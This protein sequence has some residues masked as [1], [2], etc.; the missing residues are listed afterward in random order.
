MNLNVLKSYLIKL[1]VQVDDT[2]VNKMKHVVNDLTG[3]VSSRSLVMSKAALRGAGVIVG[4]LASVD[5]AIIKN[6]MNVAEADMSYQL[7]AQK[8]FMTADAAKAFKLSSDALDASLFEIAWNAE[9]KGRY[10]ELV[11][12]INSLKTPPEAREMFREVRETAFQFT[13][14]KVSAT[15]ALEHISYNII[16]MNRGPLA[17]FRHDLEEMV[18]RFIKNLPEWSVKVAKWLNV[19]AKLSISGM[20]VVGGFFK[21]VKTV[22][23]YLSEKLD[24]LFDK[25]PKGAKSGALLGALFTPQLLLA[26]GIGS[27]FLAGMTT[28]VGLLLMIDDFIGRQEGRKTS[29]FLRPFWEIVEW[30]TTGFMEIVLGA[31]VLWD[32][33]TWKISHPFTDHP[34]GLSWSEDAWKQIGDYG[35]YADEWIRKRSGKTAEESIGFSSIFES[36]MSSK[37]GRPES[38]AGQGSSGFFSGITGDFWGGRKSYQ[39]LGFVSPLADFFGKRAFALMNDVIESRQS[40]LIGGGFPTGPYVGDSTNYFSINVNVPPSHLTPE[41]VRDVTEQAVKRVIREKEETDKIKERF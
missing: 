14:L 23:D 17:E 8:M 16:R 3:L 36:M 27:P 13:R 11:H 15:S 1:G 22:V 39:S 20:K 6:V 32:H 30:I 38:T 21:L 9:L 31:M 29:N 41:A 18:D 40:P 35:R 37:A 33:F 7:L 28:F 26:F 24:W 19:P 25:L 34:S 5:A 10:F 12:Q 4:A 2:A